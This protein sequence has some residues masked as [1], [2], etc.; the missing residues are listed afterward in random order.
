MLERHGLPEPSSLRDF[1]VHAAVA[2]GAKV[3]A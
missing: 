2:D 3:P 1:P